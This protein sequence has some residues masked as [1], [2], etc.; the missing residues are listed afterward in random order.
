MSDTAEI[1]P[2]AVVDPEARIGRNVQIGAYS[3]VGAGVSIGDD[4][5]LASHVV[6]EGPTE[7]VIFVLPEE[8]RSR[9]ARRVSPGR[10]LVTYACHRS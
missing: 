6:I 10:G 8:T 7:I 5:R 4:C 9:E 2:R 1:D 3:V